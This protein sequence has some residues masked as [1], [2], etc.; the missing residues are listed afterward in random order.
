L[1]ENTDI[2]G[3]R[4]FVLFLAFLMMTVNFMGLQ[5]LPPLLPLILKT[6][7][8]N[9]TETGLLTSVYVLSGIFLPLI[10]S[11]WMA[12]IGQKKTMI[13]ASICILIGFTIFGISH[14]YFFLILARFICGIGSA[15]F[16]IAAP[17][18]VNQ[19]FRGPNISFALAVYTTAPPF[20]SMLALNIFGPLGAVIGWRGCSFVI[21]GMELLVLFFILRCPVP[22]ELKTQSFKTY[23]ADYKK[24]FGSAFKVAL[25]SFALGSAMLSYMVFA[26]AYYR[27][28][29]Y[30]V[31]M[32]SFITSL[33]MG[34]NIFTNIII[35]RLMDKKKSR[36]RFY[37][38]L[39]AFLLGLCFILI[40]LPLVPK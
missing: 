25:I 40:S 36:K 31:Y 33:F 35:G 30:G 8:M 20:G 22:H 28:N 19:F 39:S 18:V 17:L 37:C 21:C 1:E 4:N 16:L 7:P 6:V 32:A 34:I 2:Y 14:N 10:I 27:A 26:P 5:F 15:A 12:K 9:N 24:W 38:F 23:L 13:L 29:G 11:V 3:K